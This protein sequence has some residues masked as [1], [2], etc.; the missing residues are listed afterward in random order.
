MQDR[1]IMLGRLAIVCL[2]LLL[3]GCGLPPVIVAFSYAVDGLSYASSGKSVTH[4]ALSAAADQDCAV[5]RMIQGKDVCHAEA[6]E[7]A[8]TAVAMADLK[9]P[10][11]GASTRSASRAETALANRSQAQS[12]NIR[13]GRDVSI[14]SARAIMARAVGDPT[15]INPNGLP[16]KLNSSVGH[17]ETAYLEN[18]PASTEVFALLQDNGALEIFVYGPASENSSRGLALIATYENFA[19]N[20]SSLKGI[21]IGGSF[22]AIGDLIV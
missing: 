21:S 5:F 7:G 16:V 22:H 18:F 20:P 4:H 15:L 11:E 13:A 19:D 6:L 10:D 8:V 1:A 17:P 9:S 14:V 3:A 12:W 2:P